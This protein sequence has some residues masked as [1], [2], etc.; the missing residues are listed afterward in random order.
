MERDTRALEQEQATEETAVGSGGQVAAAS[1]GASG[2]MRLAAQIGNC[3]FSGMVAERGPVTRLPL[4]APAVARR[5][6]GAGESVGGSST[7][8][9]EPERGRGQREQP[10]PITIGED[11]FTRAAARAIPR[12]AAGHIRDHEA[13]H[14]Y[15]LEADTTT[16]DEQIERRERAATRAAT[17]QARFNS[18]QY[19][20][21]YYGDIALQASRHA[22]A[23]MTTRQWERT[24]ID[25]F[26]SG[27]PD[28]NGLFASLA[29]LNGLQETMGV[30]DPQQM[31]TALQASLQDAETVGERHA[32]QL[33]EALPDEAQAVQAA[34]TEVL[35]KADNLHTRRLEMA[36][37]MNERRAAELSGQAADKQERL[38]AINETI[39]TI[40]RIGS[41]VDSARGV[42]TGA[43][44][45]IE[46]PG[47]TPP[48]EPPPG[49]SEEE[50]IA[51]LTQPRSEPQ[52]Q[53]PVYGQRAGSP[54]P[55][56]RPEQPETDEEEP[57]PDT[58]QR[59]GSAI[60][61]TARALSQADSIRAAVT[62][63][64]N[65]V[66]GAGIPTNV[67]G[68][69]RLGAT[70]IFASE[71][72]ELN[73][74]IAHLTA[75]SGRYRTLANEMRVQTML[76]DVVRAKEEFYAAAEQYRARLAS[77]QAA[78]IAL[79]RRLDAAAQRETAAQRREVGTP[80]GGER[81]STVMLA[82]SA[83]Q[84]VLAQGRLGRNRYSRG[85][86]APQELRQRFGQIRLERAQHVDENGTVGP[87]PDSEAMP[88]AEMLVQIERY[89]EF[90]GGLE[91]TYG[92]VEGA[93]RSL[94]QTI[95]DSPDRSGRY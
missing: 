90:F 40:A 52:P 72:A 9:I 20:H 24:T 70:E 28:A 80:R 46:G 75:S 27:I 22:Q 68:L 62:P 2:L 1:G 26:N 39:A 45:F 78:Y 92:P 33:A 88:L 35:L 15:A 67:E 32:E 53:G 36:A 16:L 50:Q 8:S 3:A 25:R 13:N 11:G 48:E 69:L 38:T 23:L 17:Q 49:P 71:I 77:R 42:M 14:L 19:A 4:A 94:V 59:V 63:H 66:T 5:V 95:S 81:F 61:G 91:R 84:E 37:Y 10:E 21:E 44:A 29:R 89:E 76:E 30:G 41:V 54:P 7:V 57:Q 6:T 87:V 79:G 55:H 86:L 83:I 60:E 93:V 82:A 51:A 85:G 34:G 58:R 47:R 73:Q 31:V 65:A 64:V 12:V 74:Q 56:T 43:A 18:A